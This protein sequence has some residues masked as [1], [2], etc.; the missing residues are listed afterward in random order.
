MTTQVFDRHGRIKCGTVATPAFDATLADYRDLL[1][2]ELLEQGTVPADLAAGWGAPA[3]AGARTALLRPASGNG[4]HYRLVEVEPTPDYKP[5][6]S[7]GWV[8][9]EITVEDVFDLHKKVAGESFT[10]IGPP[11]HV[12]G[13]TN[14]IPMQVVGRSG[15][16]LYLNQVLKSMSDL[17]LPMAQSVVDVIFIAILASA[18]RQASID[19]QV[20]RLGFAEG[21]TYNIPYSVINNAFGLPAENRTT[22]SMTKVERLPVTEIDQYPAGTIVRPRP[23]GGLP[24]GNAL[25]SFNVDDLD[26]IDLPFLTP[27]QARPGPLYDGRRSATVQGPDGELYELIE[28]GKGQ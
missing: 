18:D 16:I 26:R 21:G 19:F 22:I 5:A 28:T 9:F 25:I 8:A 20:G 3:V 11:K 2:L 14:F 17:D 1:G 27:P 15:E 12:E 24:P 4:C 10:V 13:F 6:R 7:F 23:A